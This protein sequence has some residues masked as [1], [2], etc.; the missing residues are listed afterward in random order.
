MTKET[1]TCLV[2]ASLTR[3]SIPL[4]H[5]HYHFAQKFRLLIIKA[6]LKKHMNYIPRNSTYSHLNLTKTQNTWCIVT[7]ILL[8]TGTELLFPLVPPFLGA[9]SPGDLPILS[10]YYL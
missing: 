4:K 3:V 7:M 1:E 2:V 8:P 10:V 5:V 9:K 6:V